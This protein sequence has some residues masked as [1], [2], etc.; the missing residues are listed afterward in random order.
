MEQV[1]GIG[2]RKFGRK[3]G[4]RIW[5]FD[6]LVWTVMAWGRDLGV[7]GKRENRKDLRKIFEMVD[8][9]ELEDTGIYD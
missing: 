2:K 8:G 3:W 9:G 6:V 5:L 4:K 7:E 1:W